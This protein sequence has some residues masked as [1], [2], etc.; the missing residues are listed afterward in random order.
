ME[1]ESRFVE[2]FHRFERVADGRGRRNS[3]DDWD[4][5]GIDTGTRRGEGESLLCEISARV[6]P[7]G[8]S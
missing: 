3:K 2:I 1:W 5:A 6:T 7:A 8:S 4:A